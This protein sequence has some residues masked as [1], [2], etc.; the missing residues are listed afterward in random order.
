MNPEVLDPPAD[1]PDR[2]CT[3]EN[4]LTPRGESNMPTDD[5]DRHHLYLTPSGSTGVPSPAPTKP[6]RAT[7]E[8]ARRAELDRICLIDIKRRQLLVYFCPLGIREI[9]HLWDDEGISQGDKEEYSKVESE[10]YLS[11][12]V[13]VHAIEGYLL[14][15]VQYPVLTAETALKRTTNTDS[16]IDLLQAE[17]DSTI[18]NFGP[19][20]AEDRT[21]RDGSPDAFAPAETWNITERG[22][23]SSGTTAPW[24]WPW[25]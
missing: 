5:Q 10:L 21:R 11:H 19:P 14:G 25:R 17:E 20:W 3:T 9:D 16:L 8:A 13:L 2:G 4:L 22:A 6:D 7:Y 24:Y 18:H 1:N 15:C 12:R 23:A